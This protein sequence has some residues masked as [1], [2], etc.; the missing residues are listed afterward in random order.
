M[1][2]PSQAKKKFPFLTKENVLRSLSKSIP[3]LLIFVCAIFPFTI[4]FQNGI[5]SGDDMIWHLTYMGDLYDAFKAGNFAL[6]PTNTISSYYA[7]DIYLFYGPFPHYLTVWLTYLFAWAGATIISSM[8]FLTIVSVYVSSLFV[9]FLAK[10]IAKST[11]IATLF[12]MAFCFFPYRIIDFLYRS[13]YCEGIAIGFIP[14]VFYGLY[15][16]LHDERPRVSAYLAVVLGMSLLIL[17]HPFTALI[18]AVAVVIDLLANILRVVQVLKKKVSWLY[19]SISI[20]LIFGFVSVYFFPMYAASRSNLYRLTQDEIMNTTQAFLIKARDGSWRMSGILNFSW[21]GNVLS[22]GWKAT[23]DTAFN[24]TLSLCLFFLSGFFTVLVDYVLRQKP[25]LNLFRPLIALVT[26]FLLPLATFAYQRLEIFLALTVF[27]LGFLYLYENEKHGDVELPERFEAKKTLKNPDLYVATGII[28]ACTL[29]LTSA[30]IWQFVPSLFYKAQFP[31][32][33][34]AILGFMGYFLIIPLVHAAKAHPTQLQILAFCAALLLAINQGPVDKRIAVSNDGVLIYEKTDDSLLASVNSVGWQNEY[35]PE[36]F[37][38]WSYVSDYSNS[39]YYPIRLTLSRWNGFPEKTDYLSP[40]VLD[41]SA[42]LTLE[43]LATPTTTFSVTVT[44]E[45]AYVQIAQFYYNGYEAL[46]TDGQG[47]TRK[48]SV[49]DQDGLLAFKL[50]QGDSKVTVHWIGST[51]YRVGR[52]AFY[53][54]IPATIGFGMLGVYLK[55]KEKPDP[56]PEP[57]KA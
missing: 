42:S 54:A 34:Y 40:A 50:K 5:P 11:Q 13:A 53:L 37:Y 20:V 49:T 14:I 10:K 2:E 35:A 47:A 48:E 3:Y 1:E 31:F 41:G 39:L 17:S 18:T 6:T 4:Y 9:F 44:S 29:L 43:Q 23:N 16:I 36:V 57:L 27:Y 33:F 26:V 12:G 45:E 32:R 56:T 15:R 30:W 24:W 51:R 22:W 55:K 21:L 46:I 25:K 19:L 8:K 38:D 7:V 52:V 28:V